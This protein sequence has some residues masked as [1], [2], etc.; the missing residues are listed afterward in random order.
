M[1]TGPVSAIAQLMFAHPPLFNFARLVSEL[2]A[3]LQVDG[4]PAGTLTWDCDDV[5]ILDLGSVRFVMAL[6]LA[7]EVPFAAC[8]TLSVGPCALA[9]TPTADRAATLCADAACLRIARRI[10]RHATPDL[11]R[12]HQVDG[13]VTTATIDALLATA[14]PLPGPPPAPPPGPPVS[15]ATF[16]ETGPRPARPQVAPASVPMRLA[17]HAMN[18]T[19]LVVAL[20]VGAALVACTLLGLGN[21]RL[22]ARAIALTGAMMGFFHSGLADPL[23]MSV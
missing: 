16:F 11:V 15:N 13:P 14:A 19:L 1:Q 8:L 6:A 10:S 12:W 17:A 7:P 3:G 22:S 4:A 20:P 5:A 21:P 9:E 18:A 23:L 2:H